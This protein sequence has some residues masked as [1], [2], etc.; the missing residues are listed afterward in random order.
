MLSL[1]ELCCTEYCI[2]VTWGCVPCHPGFLRGLLKPQLPLPRAFICSYTPLIRRDTTFPLLLSL[3]ICNP[4]AFL[5]LLSHWTLNSTL[6]EECVIKHF[7]ES[8]KNEAALHQQ[9]HKKPLSP[10]CID[11]AC[12]RVQCFAQIMLLC[13]RSAVVSPSRQEYV[14]H[15]ILLAFS[16]IYSFI[17]LTKSLHFI[18]IIVSPSPL[19]LPVLFPYQ[20]V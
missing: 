13:P 10:I 7:C 3:F 17:P 2:T 8:E 14:L 12:S 6:C 16:F 1:W 9:H 5:L 19:D 4:W 18:N 20:F 15:E 11:S